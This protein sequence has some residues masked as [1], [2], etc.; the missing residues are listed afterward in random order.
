[1]QPIPTESAETAVSIY[2]REID[3]LWRTGKAT[4]HTY[5]GA[6]Q[7][8]LSALLPGFAVLNEPKRIECGAPDYI[9]MRRGLPVAFV[10]AKDIGDPDLDGKKKTGGTTSADSVNRFPFSV[11]LPERLAR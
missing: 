6:L 9:V 10:E 5:R 3:R 2:L 4:E 1:M 7:E 11:L 8:L